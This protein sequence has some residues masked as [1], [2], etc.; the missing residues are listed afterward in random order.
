MSRKIPSTGENKDC[1]AWKVDYHVR[2]TVQIAEIN[3]CKQNF[4]KTRISN[5]KC[6]DF[7]SKNKKE[8]C[9]QFK[10]TTCKF[11]TWCGFVCEF[12]FNWPWPKK[13]RAREIWKHISQKISLHFNWLILGWLCR[14]V[15]CGTQCCC[16]TLTDRQMKCKCCRSLVWWPVNV[17]S[18][19]IYFI[20][21]WRESDVYAL[22]VLQYLF[23]EPKSTVSKFVG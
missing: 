17:T 1:L 8:K 3:L 2:A 18:L 13:V 19:L 20:C 15:A 14:R 21:Y 22:R 4:K 5:L 6:W 12:D 11:Y 10:Y 23:V 16:Q 9:F 7:C